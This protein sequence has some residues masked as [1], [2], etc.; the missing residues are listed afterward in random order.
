MAT[1]FHVLTIFPFV[2]IEVDW[3]RVMITQDLVRVNSK[4][5]NGQSLD[6]DRTRITHFG[7]L[8]SDLADP[9][10]PPKNEG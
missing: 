6:S 9:S 8:A 10:I 4:G 7:A 1:V 3:V 2:N 5:H